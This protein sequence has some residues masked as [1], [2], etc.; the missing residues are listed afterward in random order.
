MILTLGDERLL[1]LVLA[2]ILLL[3]LV[4][5]LGASALLL[6]GVP[7]LVLVAVL[8]VLLVPGAVVLI[9]GALLLGAFGGEVAGLAAVEAG[10]RSC[11]SVVEG[12][13]ELVDDQCKLL[14]SQNSNYSSVTDTREDKQKPPREGS[15]LA[16]ELPTR[17]IDLEAETS[18]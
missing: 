17:A 5:P 15:E 1:A 6:M 9:P 13:L 18:A 2:D 4:V 12:V 7:T 11:L 8:T 16:P 3:P 14:V 10:L